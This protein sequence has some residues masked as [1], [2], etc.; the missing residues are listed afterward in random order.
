MPVHVLREPL[1]HLESLLVHAEG[2]VSESFS[3]ALNAFFDLSE[4]HPLAELGVPEESEVLVAILAHSVHH[5]AGRMPP[6]HAIGL[7]RLPGLGFVHG[8]AL[9]PGYSVAFFWFDRC[10]HGLVA[11]VDLGS[12]E[13]HM[14]R[15]SMP[16]RA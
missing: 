16:R 13:T 12:C 14:M 10:E 6:S 5:V 9:V 8:T 11:V 3:P 15:V 7:A 2:E 1:A 4:A